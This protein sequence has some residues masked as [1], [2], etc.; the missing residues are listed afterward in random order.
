MVVDL[1]SFIY[2]RS[3]FA[4]KTITFANPMLFLRSISSPQKILSLTQKKLF[5]GLMLEPWPLNRQSYIYIRIYRYTQGSCG[6]RPIY[7]DDLANQ[8]G[9]FP[10]QTLSY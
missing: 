6:K 2:K 9:D 10:W 7:F 1:N 4:N 3:F 8:H 5:R